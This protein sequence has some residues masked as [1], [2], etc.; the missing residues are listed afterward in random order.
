MSV[1]ADNLVRQLVGQGHGVT[2]LSQYYGG[3]AAGCT[4]AAR[5]RRCRARR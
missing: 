4:A 1:Y 2:M 3:D 5:P